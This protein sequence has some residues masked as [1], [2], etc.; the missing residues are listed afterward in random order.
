[1]QSTSSG[2]EPREGETGCV[3]NVGLSETIIKNL[4]TSTSLKRPAPVGVSV[5]YTAR[6]LQSR[7]IPGEIRAIHG[8]N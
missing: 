7:R 2:R 3:A 5:V 6:P 8:S 1:M 4:S